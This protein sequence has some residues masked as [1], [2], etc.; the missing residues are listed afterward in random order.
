MVGDTKKTKRQK[1]RQQ[2]QLLLWCQGSFALLDNI[3]VIMIK[4]IITMIKMIKNRWTPPLSSVLNNF[5]KEWLPFWKRC[6]FH[7]PHCSHD[8][9]QWWS[10]PLSVT[11]LIIRMAGERLSTSSGPQ[12]GA[13]SRSVGTQR[14]RE[15]KNSGGLNDLKVLLKMRMILMLNSQKNRK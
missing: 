11:S 4:I 13:C 10:W 12:W 5:A 3:P 15:E 1:I 14:G 7:R 9:D 6:L 8:A 2:I